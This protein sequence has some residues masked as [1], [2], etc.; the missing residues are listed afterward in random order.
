MP[1][2]TLPNPL[3]A[4]RRADRAVNDD[5]WIIDL[6]HRVPMAAI[7]T[8][9][10]GQPFI[11][12]NLFVYDEA[13]HAIYTHTAAHGRT[14]SNIDADER[15]CVS[16]SEM[17]RLL[18]APT[19]FNMSVEYSGVAI[20]GR[21]RVV[22]DPAEKEAGLLLLVQRYFPHLEPAADYRTPDARELA[23]TSL[24]RIDI[25]AWSGKRKHVDDHPGAYDYAAT[26]APRSHP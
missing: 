6:L 9:R 4:V 1:P 18:P 21:G 25:D 13:R 5:A 14:R 22:D 2:A 17:G 11:N 23:L 3:N 16:V 10:D 8:T 12:S 26:P 24:Y 7:A 20:F 15:V 19:T